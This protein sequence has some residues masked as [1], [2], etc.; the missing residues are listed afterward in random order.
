MHTF[1]LARHA[2]RQ[3]FADPDWAATA[4]RPHDPGLS[5]D[6]VEQAKQLARRTTDLQIDHILSSPFLRTVQTAHYAAEV[7]DTALFLEPGLGEWLNADWFAAPPNTRS[8][9]SLRTRFPRIDPDHS[10]CRTPTFPESKHRALARLGATGRCL[11]DRYPDATLLLVGHGITVQGILRGL[12]GSD[13][14]DPGCPLASL[15]KVV[16]NGT[17]WSL[18]IR[19]DTRHLENGTRAAD[20]LI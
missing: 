1:W 5:D 17:G 13:V 19:N 4:D 15:T 20:R 14:P 7:L 2:N 10:A 6:G 16:Y 12:I 9:S 18:E 8:A 3:D 11:A